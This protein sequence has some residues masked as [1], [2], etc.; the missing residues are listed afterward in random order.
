M[1]PDWT[2]TKRSLAPG[3]HDAAPDRTAQDFAPRLYWVVPFCSGAR[4]PMPSETLHRDHPTSISKGHFVPGCQDALVSAV[5]CVTVVFCPAVLRDLAC[6]HRK[7]RWSGPLGGRI[8]PPGRGVW[9]RTGRHRNNTK[10]PHCAE[11]RGRR[12]PWQTVTPATS[13]TPPRDQG[14]HDGGSGSRASPVRRRKHGRLFVFNTPQ[15]KMPSSN[16][17][18][19]SA[20]KGSNQQH[21]LGCTVM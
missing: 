15:T 7:T 10:A 19:T 18:N 6:T 14:Q 5:Q 1:G 8:S 3:H 21:Y 12:R 17:K 4:S 13:P 2:G 20:P 9:W 16:T 11:A